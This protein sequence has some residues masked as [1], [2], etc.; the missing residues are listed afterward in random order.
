MT[1]VDAQ[2]ADVLGKLFGMSGSNEPEDPVYTTGAGWSTMESDEL[3]DL[4]HFTES[5]LNLRPYFSVCTKYRAL[6]T[7]SRW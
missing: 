7:W 3:S 6:Q 5:R 1:D 4:E 2:A